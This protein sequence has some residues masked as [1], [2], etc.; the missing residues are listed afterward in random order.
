MIA[1]Q[2]L[3]GVLMTFATVVVHM[4]SVIWL[5]RQ[6]AAAM[7]SVRSR[8]TG[9]RCLFL[10]TAVLALIALHLAE[11][12]AWALLYLELGEFDGLS[13]ALYFSVVTATTLGYGDMTLS[14]PWR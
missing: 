2:L 4:A 3:C 13:Q 6:L 9:E 5:G 12:G 8:G 11:A 14:E 1:P 7:G 10:S